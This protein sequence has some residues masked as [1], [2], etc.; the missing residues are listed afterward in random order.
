MEKLNNRVHA[1]LQTIF[2]NK[3]LKFGPNKV[4]TMEINTANEHFSFLWKKIHFPFFLNAKKG[5][6]CQA[7]T[8]KKMQNDN[9]NFFEDNLHHA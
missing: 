4:C 2:H 8:N 5:V 7:S 3:G 9:S 1:H 6:S